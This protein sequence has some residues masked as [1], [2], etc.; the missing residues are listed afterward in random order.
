MSDLAKIPSRRVIRTRSSTVKSYKSE[1]SQ[2]IGRD[3]MSE[4]EE[5][6]KPLS[7]ECSPAPYQI[8]RLLKLG[9]IGKLVCGAG[10]GNAD[11]D[12]ESLPDVS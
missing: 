10:S 3:Q 7:A 6:S 2:D 4:A 12:A 1:F 9:E 5:R 8:P 11:N